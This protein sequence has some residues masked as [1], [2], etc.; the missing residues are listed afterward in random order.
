MDD[1]GCCGLRGLCF[2][3]GDCCVCCFWACVSGGLLFILMGGEKGDEEMEYKEEK[4]NG[5]KGEL[6]GW[7]GGQRVGWRIHGG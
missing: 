6:P 5:R 4:R 3:W 7:G 1:L 2:I